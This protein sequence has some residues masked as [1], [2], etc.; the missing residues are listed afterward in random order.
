MR[1]VPVVTPRGVTRLPL[2]LTFGY[3]VATF[4]LFLIWPINWPIYYAS[5]WACLI[6]YV[7]V[8][9]AVIG[10]ATLAGSSALG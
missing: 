2:L 3:V 8:C 5:D 7:G 6:F 9:F 10:A 4:A 1:I